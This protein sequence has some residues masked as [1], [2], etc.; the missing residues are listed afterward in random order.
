LSD[1]KNKR[2]IYTTTAPESVGPT[3]RSYLEKMNE[4]EIIGISHNL[5]NRPKLR[6]DLEKLLHTVG[7][8]DVLLTEIKAASIDVAASTALEN[9]IPVAFCDNTPVCI[10]PALNLENIVSNLSEQVIKQ[11]Y[12]RRD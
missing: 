11:F 2:V 3:L 10:D 4:C 8:A 5:A 7:G 6:G 12:E 1:L 9:G